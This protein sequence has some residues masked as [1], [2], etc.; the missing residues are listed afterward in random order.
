M[1][2]A[3]EKKAGGEPQKALRHAL[4]DTRDFF[5]AAHGCV[6]TLRPGRQQADLLFTLP[7]Q[8]D[9]DLG[10]LTRYIR[11]THPPVERDMLI[12]SVRRRGGAWAAFAVVRPGHS[13]DRDDRHLIARITAGLSA[14]L[15]RLDR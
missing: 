5:Q 12:G 9:W 8:T 11:H 4:R 1:T 6:A 10:V 7:K 3:A 14:A 13:F 15:H 2:S